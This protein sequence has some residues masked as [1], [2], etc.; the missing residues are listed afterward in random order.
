MR[1][2]TRDIASLV[3][4]ALFAVAAQ[5]C[6]SSAPNK[7]TM[8]LQSP[9][10]ARDSIR[11]ERARIDALQERLGDNDGAPEPVQADDVGTGSS[12]GA[13]PGCDETC[14]IGS[15]VCSSSDTICEIA[16]QHPTNDA[17]SQDCSWAR[18]ACKSAVSQCQACGGEVAGYSP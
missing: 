3:I 10:E 4:A 8:R 5:G 2:R 6:A 15:S 7:D 12:A 17:F 9:E 13:M 16:E 14:Q 18:D 11:G 1:N